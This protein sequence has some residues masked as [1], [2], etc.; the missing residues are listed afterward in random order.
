MADDR[1][2]TRNRLQE[3]VV[4][5]RARIDE[6]QALCERYKERE[7]ALEF[8]EARLEVFHRLYQMGQV[9][10]PS[11]CEFALEESVKLTNSL[12]GYLCL[13]DDR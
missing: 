7:D 6:L 13:V 2:N 9:P 1:T 3:E 12:Y 8:N 4:L 5:L 11:I 10:L